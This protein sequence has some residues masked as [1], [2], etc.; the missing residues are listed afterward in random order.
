MKRPK[1]DLPNEPIDTFLDVTGFLVVVLIIGLVGYYYGTLPEEVPTHFNFKG[2]PDAW[3]HKSSMWTMPIIGAL[4]F[5]FL[6]FINKIPQHFNYPM[7]ITMDNAAVQ[8]RK[9]T[10]MIRWI[11]IASVIFFLFITWRSIQTAL[12]NSEGLGKGLIVIMGCSVALL[13][14][15]AVGQT[16]KR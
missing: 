8:Y 6:F 15:Y 4:L 2:E 3:G 14:G 13:L 5:I 10:R 7:K 9:A 16:R 12:G 1:I 11:N